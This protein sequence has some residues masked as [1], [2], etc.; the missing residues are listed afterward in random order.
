M[1]A[2]KTPADVN[3]DARDDTADTAGEGAPAKATAKPDHAAT[4]TKPDPADEP[5]AAPTNPGNRCKMCTESAL[6]GNYGFCSAHRTPK[7]S[8]TQ[9]SAD[10]RDTQSESL[11]ANSTNNAGPASK[12]DLFGDLDRSEADA[13][14]KAAKAL[15]KYT[16]A[17]RV[18][19]KHLDAEKIMENGKKDGGDG[20][21]LCG[22][23]TK[24][25]G[26]CL[27]TFETRDDLSAH[28]RFRPCAKLSP[29]T[30]AHHCL[31]CFKQLC[32]HTGRQVEHMA[33]QHCLEVDKPSPDGSADEDKT[34]HVPEDGTLLHKP[35]GKLA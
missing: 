12:S 25:G 23:S 13:G 35:F 22:C 27:A 3:A 21:Y 29:D 7:A 24:E 14:D 2:P 11:G 20:P 33:S 10:D 28:A 17:W 32:T 34:I 4:C 8:R 18:Q 15:R 30:E 26:T 16:G 5:P 6:V 9:P 1:R 19:R 31:F